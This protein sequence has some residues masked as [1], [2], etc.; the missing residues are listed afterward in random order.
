MRCRSD[1]CRPLAECR[2]VC[3]VRC[4]SRVRLV[5]VATC[6]SWPRSAVEGLGVHIV[7]LPEARSEAAVVNIVIGTLLLAFLLAFCAHIVV[8]VWQEC[9]FQTEAAEHDELLDRLWS[10]T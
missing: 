2:R 1:G 4:C 7:F 8:D 9:R 3:R 6:E 10:D 5:D